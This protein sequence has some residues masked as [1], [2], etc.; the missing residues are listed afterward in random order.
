MLT[1]EERVKFRV[2]LSYLLYLSLISVSLIQY[3]YAMPYT[4]PSAIQ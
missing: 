2:S 3:R 1:Y 4:T